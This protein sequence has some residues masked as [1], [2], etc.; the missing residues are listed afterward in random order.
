MS[1]THENAGRKTQQE[2]AAEADACALR[3][4]FQGAIPPVYQNI[5][6]IL[7]LKHRSKGQSLGELSWQ[8]FQAVD[9]HVQFAFQ[10]ITFYFPNENA[11]AHFGQ[12]PGGIG[13]SLSANGDYLE[14]QVRI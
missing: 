10:Q 2:C 11:Q 13:I 9:R 1:P 3:Q 5:P 6:R 12:C 14:I 4:I 8:V 7:A